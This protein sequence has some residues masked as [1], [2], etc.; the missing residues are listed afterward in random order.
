MVKISI[1]VPVYNVEQYIENCLDSLVK[2]TL[3]DIEIIIVDDGSPDNSSEI[4]NKYAKRDNRIKIIKKQNAGVSEARNTGMEAA[5]GEFYMFVDSDDWLP[6]DSCEI[7]YNEYTRSQAD[8]IL[9]DAYIV[10]NGKVKKNDVFKEPFT[11]NDPEFF[12]A[13][14]KTCIGYCYNPNPAVKWNIPGLGSPWNKLFN[15][16]IIK[17]NN[18][19]FDPYVKGIYDDNLF[20]L[21][22]LMHIKSL[23]YVKKPVYY[24]RLVSGSLT[25]GYKKNTLDINSRI[26]K[27]IDEFMTA[28]GNREYYL[29]AFY[30]YVIRRFSKSMNVYFFANNNDK[31]RNEVFAE[32][33]QVMNLEPYKTAI[34]KVDIARLLGN[35][36]IVVILSRLKS[37]RLIWLCLSTKRLFT[38]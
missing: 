35:H 26:F 38:K 19:R 11:T 4:Y 10:T 1:I 16:K 3:K 17:E 6:L 32:L 24:F 33:K 2:Q 34:K 27:R 31:T 30:V 9:A 37:P 25:Q 22:Y 13:Y 20:T 8:M 21:Y 14:Q 29:E 12:K 5:T 28:T 36:K 7:L 23:S 15:S 18:L